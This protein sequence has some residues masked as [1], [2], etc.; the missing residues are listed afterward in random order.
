MAK[1]LDP[2]KSNLSFL[3]ISYVYSKINREARVV[4]EEQQLGL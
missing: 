4:K 2:I 1:G 3:N